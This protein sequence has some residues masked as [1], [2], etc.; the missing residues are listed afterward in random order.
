MFKIEHYQ[1]AWEIIYYFVVLKAVKIFLE[2]RI[3]LYSES[4]HKLRYVLKMLLNISSIL[5][6][7]LFCYCKNYNESF[8]FDS[9]SN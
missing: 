6:E 5:K 8:I 7:Y 1:Y 3:Y 2:K 4:P 9:V